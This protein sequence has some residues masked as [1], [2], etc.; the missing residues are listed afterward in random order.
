MRRGR[1]NFLIDNEFYCTKCGSKGIPIARKKGQEREAGHLKKLFCLKCKD[2]TNHVECKP[3]SHY[4]HEDFLFEFENGNFTETGRRKM[5]YGEFR[6]M[7]YNNE[8]KERGVIEDEAFDNFS[9]C[10]RDGEI[11]FCN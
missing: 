3:F 7:M 1:N 10:T 11:Y 5:P 8:I 4:E 9:G 6:H 2:E